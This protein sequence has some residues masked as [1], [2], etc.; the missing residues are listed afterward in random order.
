MVTVMPWAEAQSTRFTG[1]LAI[2]LISNAIL[3]SSWNDIKDL[4]KHNWNWFSPWVALYV[5]QLLGLIYSPDQAEG[6]IMLSVRLGLLWIPLVVI[7][8]PQSIERWR[9]IAW[10]FALS[11]LSVLYWIN[12]DGLVWFNPCPI[13]SIEVNSP[14]M[15]PYLASF[16]A[17][18][19]LLLIGLYYRHSDTRLKAI[20]IGAGAFFTLTSAFVY[21]KMST[22][23]ILCAAIICL[24]VWTV[25]QRVLKSGVLRLILLA[26]IV[27]FANGFLAYILSTKKNVLLALIDQQAD[28]PFWVIESFRTRFQIWEI[29][30]I[31]LFED[32]TWLLGVGTGGIPSAQHNLYCQVSLSYCQFQYNPHNQY[33]E[34]WLQSGILGL[35]GL[36]VW[37]NSLLRGSIRNNNPFFFIWV[38]YIIM[39]LSTECM[40]TREAGVL[41]IGLISCI[42]TSVRTE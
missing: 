7:L 18:S 21:A 33:L 39:C 16:I 34:Q 41:L 15:R 12:R 8:K 27:A 38:C 32:Y 28:S 35:S 25:G 1:I 30:K 11:N 29:V 3:G 10:A 40:L 9:I 24:L 13:C 23:S 42:F 31:K 2:L 26:C 37:S 36:L 17:A 22:I 19:G 5:I 20:G 14:Q 6:G 4:L